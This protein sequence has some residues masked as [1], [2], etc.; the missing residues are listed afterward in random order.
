M[1]DNTTT[2]TKRGYL[3]I[4]GII[5]TKLNSDRGMVGEGRRQT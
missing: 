5:I 2:T 4:E 3:V 1:D